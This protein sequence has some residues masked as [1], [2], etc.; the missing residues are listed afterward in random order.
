MIGPETDKVRI[1]KYDYL[2]ISGLHTRSHCLTLAARGA[3][4]D[5]S[6]GLLGQICGFIGG[7]VVYDD[8]FID[9]PGVL[10]LLDDVGD[11]RR[12]IEGRNDGSSSRGMPFVGSS[13]MRNYSWL[14]RY[15][16][17]CAKKLGFREVRRR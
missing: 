6:A 3:A 7:G 17:V 10:R 5:G 4:N 2:G 1:E 15:P 16:L 13:R 11:R 14:N 9:Q 8:D 12:L